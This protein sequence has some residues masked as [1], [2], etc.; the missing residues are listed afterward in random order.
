MLI[1]STELLERIKRMRNDVH[2]SKAYFSQFKAAMDC[3]DKLIDI[4]ED[5]E[6]TASG[7]NAK[8]INGR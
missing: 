7:N 5:M 2:E 8:N 6:A 4:I 3:I 1:E